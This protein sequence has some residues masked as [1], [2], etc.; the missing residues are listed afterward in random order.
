V[1]GVYGS[2]ASAVG[3]KRTSDSAAPGA[4][5]SLGSSGGDAGS[6][7]SKAGAAGGSSGSDAS[8]AALS[9]GVP[10]RDL[11]FDQRPWR[12]LQVKLEGPV[13]A[14]LQNAFLRQWKK[15]AH[16]DLD[17]HDKALFPQ[18]AARGREIVRVMES[19]AGDWPNPLYVALVSAIDNAET[20]VLVMNA[21]FVPHP[22]LLEALQ[23]AAKRGVT[24][25]LV[26]PS[27]SDN[28]LVLQAGHSYYEDLLESG[29]H[30]FERQTRLLHAKSALVDGVWCTIGSTNLDWRSLA[31]ND[32][33]NAVVLSPDFAEQLRVVFDR[34]VR[35]S[36]EI[37]REDW[38]H[39]G[40]LNRLK[41]RG[42]R[43]WAMLL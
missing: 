12:D 2:N 43:L 11:P 10:L 18:L 25:K 3:S 16:E 21:Y 37:T 6:S 8:R 38:K 36:H 22:D 32:E 17:P 23:R 41:E 9:P 14:D 29:V 1:S 5:G 42:A 24:V 15:A 31:Y 20:E 19:S 27:R 33:L 7:G 26:L 13:V 28:E 30:I 4:S 40:L 34:D 35:D 39:R